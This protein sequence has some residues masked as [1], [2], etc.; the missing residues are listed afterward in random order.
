VAFKPT[1]SVVVETANADVE[2]DALRRTLESIVAQRPVLD[3]ARDV[4][5]LIEPGGTD[6]TG[7]RLVDE[8][9]FLRVAEAPARSYAQMKAHAAAVTTGEVIVFADSDCVYGQGWLGAILEPFERPDVDVVTGETAIRIRGPYSLAVAATFNFPGFTDDRDVAPASR[10]WANNVALRRAALTTLAVNPRLSRG[11]CV[12]HA[13]SLRGERSLVLRQPAAR[14]HH[15]VIAPRDFVRRYVDLGR[16]R[17]VLQRAGVGGTGRTRHVAAFPPDRDG[18]RP[19]TRVARRIARAVAQ[20]P[21]RAVLVPPAMPVV[22]A[23]AVLHA[24][25]RRRPR[26]D[27]VGVDG[28]V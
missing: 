24:A 5:L 11:Q 23:A 10:Y 1:F 16:D 12:L 21:S 15:D 18:D 3:E 7:R 27:P 28:G 14:A 17:A 25:G 13:E 6:A 2:G 4:V 26:R 22:A 20:H 9:P 19:T 8:Y